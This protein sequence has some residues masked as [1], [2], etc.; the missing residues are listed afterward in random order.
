MTD[1]LVKNIE[2]AAALMGRPFTVDFLKRHLADLP[3]IRVGEGRGR[4]GRVGFTDE[5]IAEIIRMFTVGPRA[6]AAPAGP[7]TRRRAS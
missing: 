6:K 5:Q 2:Q 7:L 4:G 1:P 3:H